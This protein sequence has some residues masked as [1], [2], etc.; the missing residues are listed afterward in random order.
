MTS[1]FIFKLIAIDTHLNISWILIWCQNAYT[2]L[3]CFQHL[4]RQW[5]WDQQIR[6]DFMTLNTFRPRQN[7]RHFADAIL[8]CIFLN[9]NVWIPTEISLKFVPKGPIDNI[10]ALV[11]IMAWRRPDQWWLDY[12][13][14]YASLGLNELIF[15]EW[16]VSDE[17][18]ELI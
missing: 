2:R 15:G 5:Q 6:L 1:L 18:K 16:D 14:I 13:R 10:Q 4:K 3:K 7:G 12:R 8:K 17:S 9:E 11:K